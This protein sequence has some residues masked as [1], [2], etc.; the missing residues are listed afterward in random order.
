[1]IAKFRYGVTLLAVTLLLGGSAHVAQEPQTGT[2][3][4]EQ[5]PTVTFRT[6]VDFVEVHAVVT[7]E[8]GAFVRG[9]TRDDFEIYEEGKP[10]TPA[11]FAFIDTP[12][13]PR[14]APLHA[15]EPVDADVRE[16]SETFE[17]RV[18]VLLLDD[19]HTGIVQTVAVKDA[20]RRFVEKYMGANDWAAVLHASGR[21]DA[22]Q[23]LTNSPRLLLSAIDK[24]QGRKLPSAG[25]ERLAAHLTADNSPD[26]FDQDRNRLDTAENL[27]YHQGTADPLDWERGDKARRVLDRL[28][29]VAEQM[30]RLSGRRKALLWFSE[31]I[32]YD[33]YQP[34]N[35]SWA[36]SLLNKT[37]TTV[38]AAQRANVSVY[39]V[40]ARGL[41]MLGQPIMASSFSRYPQLQFGTILGTL[42][43]L[44]LAQESLVSLADQTG[45]IAVVNTNDV[46]GAL[47]RIALDNSRYYL[48]GYYGD[49]ENWSQGDFREI[50]V[51]VSRPGVSVR[52]RRGFVVPSME[53]EPSMPAG[54]AA[55]SPASPDDAESPGLRA[56]LDT[57]L[58]VGEL[59]LRVF[60]APFKITD[61]TA[62]VLVVAEVDGRALRFTERDGRFQETLELSVAAVDDRADVEGGAEQTLKLDLLPETRERVGATGLRLL[63]HVELPA[64]ER[65]QLRVGVVATGSGISGTVPY[66]LE[67]ADY[68]D[69]PFALSGLVLTSS[70]ANAI[71]TNTTD[72]LTEEVL[73]GPPTATRQFTTAETLTAYL[74]LYDRSSEREHSVDVEATVL[75]ASDG[76][77]VFGSR[78][79]RVVSAGAEPPIQGFLTEFAL[80]DFIPGMY[81]LRVTA[82][83]LV[84][85]HPAAIRQVPFATV[86]ASQ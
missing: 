80:T 2:S 8:N 35:R 31:G 54:T 38:A 5:G 29:R 32:D 48:L 47:A 3:P 12:V 43:E 64:A 27:Q 51:R 66:D 25:A 4:A 49:L 83:S 30:A 18:Y 14:F 77:E 26:Q 73:P 10:Q 11:V 1:M 82:T 6:G 56:A 79:R 21:A 36:S 50:E 42:G 78:D 44:R 22:S 33:I 39:A 23:E 55:G 72:P 40:D 13:E 76:Q 57:L 62:T 58:P 41:N 74:E 52:S 16:T 59:P 20:A 85:E 84:G 19:L 68:E 67:I 75:R 65:Y 63:T 81:V 7:D 71:P 15:V 70:A 60:A 53:E 37:Q 45:G 46:D 61:Q 28:E 17:G 69:V 34:F 24:F 86:A 9:L